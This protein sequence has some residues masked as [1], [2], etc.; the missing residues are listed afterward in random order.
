M[1]KF[2]IE[3]DTDAPSINVKM[4]G[5]EVSDIDF[6]VFE[7]YQDFDFEKN[8]PVER[9]HANITS[10]KKDESGAIIKTSIYASVQEDIQRY[11]KGL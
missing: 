5:N 3:V 1:P 11:L 6:V 10:R 7:R 2:S 8:Q 9:V 4:N